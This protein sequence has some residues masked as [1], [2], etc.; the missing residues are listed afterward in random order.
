MP[1]P[2]LL[3]LPLLLVALAACDP[4]APTEYSAPAGPSG[5]RVSG[6]A[7]I[8]VSSDGLLSNSY[9]GSG[10]PPGRTPAEREARQKYYQ[11]PRGNEF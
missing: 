2:K 5:V 9:G 6:S 11:G 8:G 7:A 1:R 10:P 3:L 4:Y